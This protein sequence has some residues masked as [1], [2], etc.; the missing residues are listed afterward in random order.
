MA[1]ILCSLSF[2]IAH[3]DPFGELLRREIPGKMELGI[4]AGLLGLITYSFIF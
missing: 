1:N 3:P 2:G 4:E